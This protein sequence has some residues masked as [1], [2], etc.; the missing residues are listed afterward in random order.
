MA[1]LDLACG[2]T[3]NISKIKDQDCHFL[4]FTSK[5]S[6][7]GELP[8]IELRVHC[9]HDLVKLLDEIIVKIDN[10]NDYTIEGKFYVYAVSYLNNICDIKL[11]SGTPDY[12][13]KTHS[14]KFT[15]IKNAVNSL[16]PQ[17]P[18][19][20]DKNTDTDLLNDIELFQVNTTDYKFLNR[21]LPGWK[22]DTI[23]GF[24]LDALRINDLNS[25]KY[26][27]EEFAIKAD[28]SEISPPQLTEPKLYSK[29][30]KFIDYSQGEDPNHS[31]IYY[32]DS[33]VA[34]NN[35]YRDLL[36]NHTHNTQ[37]NSTKNINNVSTRI[38]VPVNITDG[39]RVTDLD[40]NIHNIYVSS[41]SMHIQANT[42]DVNYTFKS[43]K[44][45]E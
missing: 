36:A 22:K 30:T 20:I 21:L 19:Y 9:D 33:Y 4:S 45:I 34:V 16:Y 11:M 26:K 40:A 24:S 8:T 6:I 41:R 15:N 31:L 35:E 10:H 18:N 2:I 13:R 25:F 42:I 5:E 23:Y 3:L 44:P 1:Q 14:N 28:L 17:I 39:I 27:W 43:M 7:L 32:G 29:E 12:T 38:L 37:F